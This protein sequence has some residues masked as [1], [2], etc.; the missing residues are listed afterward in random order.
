MT[1]FGLDEI[2][3]K[4]RMRGWIHLYAFCVAV[5]CAITLVTL[6][7]SM[8]SVSAGLPCTPSPCAECSVSAPPTIA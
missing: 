4:P 2:P 7:F 8:V 5:V 3:V 1:M 6:A